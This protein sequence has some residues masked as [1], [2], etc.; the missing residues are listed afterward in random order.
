MV[1][2]NEYRSFMMHCSV[3]CIVSNIHHMMDGQQIEYAFRDANLAEI[4]IERHGSAAINPS[5]QSLGTVG[6]RVLVKGK[7]K[8]DIREDVFR[9]HIYALRMQDLSLER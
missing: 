6:Y 2:L 7:S 9:K 4:S 8:E 3:W 1:D 5:R